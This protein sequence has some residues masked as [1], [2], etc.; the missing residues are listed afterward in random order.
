MN[1][2][3]Q[4]CKT[5]RSDVWSF[6]KKHGRHTLPWRKTRDPYR[7]LVSEIML[8]QT[9]VDRVVPYYKAWFK[10]FPTIHVLAKAPLKDVLRAW[11]GLGYNRRA[12]MLHETAKIISKNH[13]G[14]FPKTYEALTALPG[15]GAYT[16]GA[17]LAFAFNENGVFVETN[18][19]T[20]ITHHFFSKKKQVDD[21][22]V[23][24]VL[25]KISPQGSARQWNWALMDYGAHLK[26]SGVRVN[27]KMK[28]YVK[29]KKFQGS[30]REARGA[31]LKALS[32]GVMSTHAVSHVLGKE[33]KTQVKEQI[34][35]LI[36]EG[37]IEGKDGLFW[38]PE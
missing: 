21:A 26:R 1:V 17:V 35:L 11:Q 7:I 15:V 3:V 8:Q 6:Y 18:I 36:Q 13:N 19:R 10:V 38:L 22:Q 33:R 20:V 24:A 32:T 23:Y 12:K 5:F 31:I 9:Q 25:Q 28:G 30:A 29:Q 14:V 16:A 4:K 27:A 34:A 2:S 37:L